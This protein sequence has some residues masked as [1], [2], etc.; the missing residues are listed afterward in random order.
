[1]KRWVFVCLLFASCK[2]KSHESPPV[3]TAPP[4]PPPIGAI[5][6]ER[7]VK[8]CADYKRLA[9]ACAKESKDEEIG[10]QCGLADTRIEALELQLRVAQSGDGMDVRDR[11][12]V[13][14][15]A[16][17]IM[18]GCIQSAADLRSHCAAPH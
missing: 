4:G 8:A 10:R 7:G 17:R 15:E 18:D 9:C 14:V 13:R 6:A 16:R 5:E 3:T 2:G 1:M 11:A 12:V